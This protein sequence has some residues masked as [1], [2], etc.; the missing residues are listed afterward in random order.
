MQSVEKFG[1]C[2]S[3]QC[4]FTEH[5]VSWWGS[6]FLEADCRVP[7]DLHEKLNCFC[8]KLPVKSSYS[9]ESRKPFGA[10][11]YNR[12]KYGRMVFI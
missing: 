6:L 3:F 8:K 4:C 9:E 11:V 7:I 5:V 12:D 2:L 10:A 1:L